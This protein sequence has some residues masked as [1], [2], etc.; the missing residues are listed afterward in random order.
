MLVGFL[1]GCVISDLFVHRIA[2]RAFVVVAGAASYSLALRKN[3]VR[4]CRE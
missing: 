3:C 2:M 1:Y 4:E